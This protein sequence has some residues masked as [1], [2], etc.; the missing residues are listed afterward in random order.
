[1]NRRIIYVLL[2]SLLYHFGYRPAFAAEP[3]HGTHKSPIATVGYKDKSNYQDSNEYILI[4]TG[5]L[6]NEPEDEE[7]TT[8][9]SKF[10]HESRWLHYQSLKAIPL[11]GKNSVS[12]F[13]YTTSPNK[14]KYILNR[15]FRV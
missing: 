10:N 4:D 8:P 13:Y 1:M 2:L 3:L 14:E 11:A 15:V 12:H 7:E 6:L 9:F 5:I